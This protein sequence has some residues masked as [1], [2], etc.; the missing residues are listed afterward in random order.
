M[1]YAGFEPGIA[2]GMT[3]ADESR[4]APRFRLLIRAAKL[5]SAYGEFV[6]VLRDV[7]STGVSVKLFHALP[8]CTEMQLELQ[9]GDKFDLEHRW[10]RGREAGFEFKGPV[11]VDRVISEDSVFPKRALRLG[12]Q[13]PAKLRTMS[14][15][16]EAFVENLSQQGARIEC[17]RLFAIDQTVRIEA[18][19]VPEI[20]AKVRWRNRNQ[21]GVVFDDTFTFQDLA[22]VAAK[23]Q[24]PKLL[25][26]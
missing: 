9:C 6:C 25:S 16:S 10:I 13:F 7:S 26:D 15:D 23:I 20:R 17:D 5:V 1:D 19:G 21:Y 2:S 22:I 12:L 14:G 3:D 11:N 8:E 24:C 18:A 4:H